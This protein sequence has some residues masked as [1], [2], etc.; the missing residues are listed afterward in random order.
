M[1]KGNTQSELLGFRVSEKFSRRVNRLA[2][3]DH[4]S[5][6]QMSRLLMERAVEDMERDMNLPDIDE[7]EM[8]RQA[9]NG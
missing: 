8:Q 4:R 6:S 5:R 3:L 9:V 7:E 2:T 1:T